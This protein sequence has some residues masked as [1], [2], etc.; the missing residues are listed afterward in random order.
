[1]S[2]ER[3]IWLVENHH[4]NKWWVQ[5]RGDGYSGTSH[6]T[7]ETPEDLTRA[8]VVCTATR[9]RASGSAPTWQTHR[10]DP[11]AG[12][13]WPQLESSSDEPTATQQEMREALTDLWDAPVDPPI[14]WQHRYPLRSGTDRGPLPARLPAAGDQHV[15]RPKL[16]P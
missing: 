16:P 7:D 3:E 1:M 14:G 15:P 4:E 10:T 11:G 5:A 2:A 9:L 8:T 13:A 6:I 12:P